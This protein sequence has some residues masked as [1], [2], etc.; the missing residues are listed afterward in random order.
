MAENNAKNS[1]IEYTA[2]RRKVKYPRLEFKTGKLLLV[3][4]ENQRSHVEVIE[5]HRK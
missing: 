5:K 2:V 3:L 1:N 4:P